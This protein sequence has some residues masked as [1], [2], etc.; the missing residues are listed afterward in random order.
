M[1]SKAKSAAKPKVEDVL[2]EELKR[3][4]FVTSGL[5]FRYMDDWDTVMHS[6]YELPIEYD[7]YVKKVG[8]MKTL[9]EIVD[10]LSKGDFDDVKRSES[11]RKQMK[12]F[13]K[14]MHMYYN[15]IFTKGSDKTGYGALIHFPQLKDKDPDR[16]SGIVLMAKYVLKG[17]KGFLTFEKARFDDFLLEVRPFIEMLGNLYRKTR[18]P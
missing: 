8:E 7:G 3:E 16:S 12:E 10:I 15:L 18:K 4:M 14:T 6:I 11:R 13:V 9:K 2:A 17:G 5:K 1:K